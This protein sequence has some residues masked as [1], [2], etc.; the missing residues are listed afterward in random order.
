MNISF[1]PQNKKQIIEPS[2]NPMTITPPPQQ[3]SEGF[4]FPMPTGVEKGDV[5]YWNPEAGIEATGAWIKL[6]APTQT[7]PE[8]P[9]FLKHDGSDIFWGDGSG[10]PEGTQVYQMLYW[11]GERWILL[12]APSF[13]SSENPSFLRFTGTLNWGAGAALPDGEN[14][15]DLLQWDPSVGEN[16][17]WVV[18]SVPEASEENPKFLYWNGDSWNFVETK[19]FDICKNG[20]PKLY[21]IPAIEII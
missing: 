14:F 6:D 5:V 7:D 9:V 18:L 17:G 12:N 3:N 11:N 1:I 10:L 8:D 20:V 19:T 4:F 2:S 15:G 16:G 13:G 21:K